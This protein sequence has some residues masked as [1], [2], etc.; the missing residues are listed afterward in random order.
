MKLMTRIAVLPLFAG[1]AGPSACREAK[2]PVPEAQALKLQ[3]LAADREFERR[4]AQRGAGGWADSFAEDAL[5]IQGS[6]RIQG[7]AA[8]L[9][10]MKAL[11]DDPQRGLTWTPDTAWASQSGDLGVTIGSF[12]SWRRSEEG[13]EQTVAT[14]TYITVWQR[15]E[16]GS[17]K[18]AL[19]GGSPDP[20]PERVDQQ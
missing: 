1:L 9:E 10:S 15:Q 20:Q 16:D 5:M 7:R 14:G 4:T 8:I 3:L 11:L 2:P 17:W 19:D 13:E 18:V 6:N 12:R